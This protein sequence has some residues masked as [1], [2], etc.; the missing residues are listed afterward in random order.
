MTDQELERIKGRCE[1]AS[2]S[3]G[4]GV[5]FWRATYMNDVPRLIE[6]VEPKEKLTLVVEP[7][8]VQV[9]SLESVSNGATKLMADTMYIQGNSVSRLIADQLCEALGHLSRAQNCFMRAQGREV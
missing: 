7:K 1:G 8:P 5:S 2:I 3:D 4:E 9:V 6:A